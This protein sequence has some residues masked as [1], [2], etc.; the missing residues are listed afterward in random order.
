MDEQYFCGT[1]IQA[2]GPLAKWPGAA[3]RIPWHIDTS[4]YSGSRLTAD[5]IRQAFATAWKCW[6]DVVEIDTPMASA[7]TEALVRSHFARIDG[8]SSVLA[9][10]EL[11]NNT[12]GPK[13]QRYDNGESWTLEWE[14]AGIPL[15]TVAIH[16][17]GH[18]LGLDH[19]SG[20]ANA[21]MRP[22]VSR[23]LPRATERDFQ[24]LVGLGY[25]RRTSP[26][27]NSPPDP[28]PVSGAIYPLPGGGELRVD[29]PTRVITYPTGWSGSVK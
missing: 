12:S 17:I 16:E 5:V 19:D 20:N 29:Y 1:T 15:V 14:E 10:S 6:A 25:K 4:G 23:S 26:P 18:A 28:P 9:W 13:T 11:A 7:A 24:R 2:I 3:P 22:S 21:I 8:P 27:P